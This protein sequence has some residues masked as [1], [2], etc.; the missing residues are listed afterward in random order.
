MVTQK[1]LTLSP[2]VAKNFVKD[3]RAFF[4]EEDATKRDVIAAWQLQKS[5]R[6]RAK[7]HLDSPTSNRCSA[8]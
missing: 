7:S 4:A 1:S 8:R 6:D 5:T 2:A 3:M